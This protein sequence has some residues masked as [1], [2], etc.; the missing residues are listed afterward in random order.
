IRAFLA[1]PAARGI[2]RAIV[3]EPTSCRAGWRH[4][5]IGSARAAVAGPGG[6][7]SRADAT[8]NPIAILARAAVALDDLGRERRLVGPPGFEGLC[9]N[10]ASIDGGIAFNVIPTTGA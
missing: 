3:C 1:S 4:R 8:P 5:G 10:I 2:E 9:M 7:S 6:H